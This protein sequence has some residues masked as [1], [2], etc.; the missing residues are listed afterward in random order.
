MAEHG[1][2]E[3]VIGVCLDGTGYGDDGKIW[4]SEFMVANLDRTIKDLCILIMFLCQAVIKQ[5]MNHGEWHTL[6]FTV[7]WE[8]VLIIDCCLFFRQ[9]N[10]KN[11]ILVREMLTRNINS[12]LTS[13]AGRLF[14]AV[15]ALLGLCSDETFDSEAPM[16][17][18]SLIDC[19]TDEYYPFQIGK[20]ISFAETF[21]ALLKD[22][23]MQNISLISAKFHNTIA[24]IIL[25]ASESI[26]KETSLNKVVLSGGVFQNKY[27]LEKA[28][29]LLRHS[30]FETFTNHLVPSNDGGISLGQLI[31]ASKKRELCA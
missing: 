10:R 4:G 16:R 5:L 21:K 27:L 9:L 7:S 25:Q 8:I 2:D 22:I 3:E 31:I 12:P 28:L 15:S 29:Y 17:L 20:E 26:R 23:P 18:E 19:E 11:L 1:I 13:G 30:G 24:R 14:D 6:T